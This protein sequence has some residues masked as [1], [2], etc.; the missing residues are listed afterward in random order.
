MKQ[1]DIIIV[2]GGAAGFCSYKCYIKN[3][4]LKVIILEQSKDVLNK[5]K[6]SG[7]RCNVT[8]ACFD[9]KLLTSY[10]PR[11]QKNYWV[12]FIF[13]VHMIP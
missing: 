8:H 2:G 5:V 3:P 7:G 11:G 1:V 9:P 4:D 6:I 10:Y 12:L 13:L